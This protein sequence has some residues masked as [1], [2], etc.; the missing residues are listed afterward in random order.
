M[1]ICFVLVLCSC[2][3]LAYFRVSLVISTILM[4]LGLALLTISFSGV[5][6]SVL[7]VILWAMWGCIGALNFSSV[8]GNYLLGPGQRLHERKSE[9]LSSS[10]RAA[11]VF[12]PDALRQHPYT[13]QSIEQDAVQEQD[14]D[15]IGDK[16]PV[17]RH[18]DFVLHN[19]ACALYLNVKSRMYTNKMDDGYQKWSD[20]V[21]AA[22]ASYHTIVEYLFVLPG[23]ELQPNESF[24][25]RIRNIILQ[26]Q[27]ILCVVKQKE[28][29]REQAENSLILSYALTE[30][31]SSL[32]E[33]LSALLKNSSKSPLNWLAYGILFPLCRW[34]QP[35]LDEL[36]SQA[37]DQI[38]ERGELSE[39][40]RDEYQ[41]DLAST[42]ESLIRFLRGL[43]NSSSRGV[44][45]SFKEDLDLAIVN[46][47]FNH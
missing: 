42:D 40:L 34:A 20:R 33:N 46:G 24:N 22:T 28:E 9:H 35:P 18:L 1:L 36:R 27:L 10:Q 30:A 5:A 14:A 17:W 21:R 23:S 15:E 4:G 37:L 25:N 41:A 44:F 7:L 11:V 16:D 2:I 43:L 32:Y 47:D 38:R 8:R 26:L 3:A 29:S 45:D 13:E 6:V 31:F 12:V 39:E 19:I